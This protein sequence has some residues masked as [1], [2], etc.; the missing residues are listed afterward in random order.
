MT[1][2]ALRHATPALDYLS[3]LKCQSVFNFVAIPAVMA[4]ATLE[5]CFMNPDVLKKNVKIR[6]GEAIKV[7]TIVSTGHDDGLMFASSIVDERRREPA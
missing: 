7:N 6:K 2:D 1:L 5:R 3:L 4:L